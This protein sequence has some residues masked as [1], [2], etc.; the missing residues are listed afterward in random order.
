MKQGRDNL[1]RFTSCKHYF[2][3]L[4]DWGG[5]ASVPNGTFDCS[6]YEC[7]HC[8][9]EADNEQAD[10]ARDRDIC[11]QEDADEARA[12]YQREVYG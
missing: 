7:R 6:R 10:M 3:W 4:K 11:R 2:V 5:D 12:S 8:G 1:G 9:A